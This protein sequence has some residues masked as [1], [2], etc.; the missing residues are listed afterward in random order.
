LLIS[1]MQQFPGE[2][3]DFIN[4][5]RDGKKVLV[6][7]QADVAPG[8]YYL[9]DTDAKKLR[10]VAARASWIKPEQLAD[11]QPITVTARDGL[12]LHGY[13]TRPAGRED[14]KNLPLVV[15]VH[16]G[17]Y[18][19][20]DTWGY[21][22]TVQML[23]SRG[24]AVLQVNFRGSG[25]YGQEFMQRGY[26]EW[27]RKMQDDVTD[28]TRWAIAEGIA[29]AKRI[30]IFGTSYGGYAALEGV[31]REPDLYQCAI[32]YV[33][34]YDLRLMYTRGDIP[35]TDYGVGYL[36]MVL[37]G[38]QDDLAARS[39]IN[40]LD[41]IK[42]RLMIVVGGQ[43]ERVPPVHGERLHAALEERGVEHEWLY[44]RTEG[45]G[46]YDEAHVADLYTR[47][48][49]F[50]DRNIGTEPAVAAVK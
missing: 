1:L 20:R 38:N 29:D 37:G 44:Q 5:S 8:R 35:Q 22:P 45:H 39:P 18:G 17:P 2:D 40:H 15:L 30:C 6:K 13:L 31:V 36:N 49:A 23:A 9:Y 26:R 12:V 28:A 48:I 33:G 34:V 32:G 10:F 19:V 41:K 11:M 50:L 4:A 14:A 27:G 25:G 21:D 3:V 46:F 7:V 42:A 47:V 16:G 24:Y 43:D